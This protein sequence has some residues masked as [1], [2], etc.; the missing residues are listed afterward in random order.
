MNQ[1]RSA[2]GAFPSPEVDAWRVGFKPSV[3]ASSLAVALVFLLAG[4]WLAAGEFWFSPL[5]DQDW[6][7]GLFFLV[8]AFTGLYFVGVWTAAAIG[9]LR[10]GAV[11]A[12]DAGGINH[13][14]LG[15][16]AWSDLETV[17]IKQFS[18]SGPH[19]LLAIFKLT[20]AQP[21]LQLELFLKA[22]A[23]EEVSSRLNRLDRIAL[24][25]A[26]SFYN[27]HREVDLHCWAFACDAPELAQTLARNA[28]AHRVQVQ[29]LTIERPAPRPKKARR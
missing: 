19:T 1:P 29:D 5:A 25:T 14:A 28:A 11:L 10:N 16:V 26:V 18:G 6:E 20:S 27:T 17:R 9:R 7:N 23:Y 12:V 4:T 2:A 15:R 8:F 3:V 24:M 13:F 22:E 21:N